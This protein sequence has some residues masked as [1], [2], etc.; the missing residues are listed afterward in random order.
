MRALLSGGTEEQRQRWLPAIARGEKLVAVATT[1]P[2]HGS[3]V[4]GI[5]CRAERLADGWVVNGTKVWRTF[6]GHR[7]GADRRLTGGDRS[8]YPVLD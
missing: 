1:E 6:E 8:T 7:Q 5:R 2:D 4:A 3:D